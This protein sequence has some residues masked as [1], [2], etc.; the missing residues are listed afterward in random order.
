MQ[1]TKPPSTT[2]KTSWLMARS[3]RIHNIWLLKLI[4]RQI[5]G[6]IKLPA[7]Q[8]ISHRTPWLS[9]KYNPERSCSCPV[10]TSLPQSKEIILR[11]LFRDLQC[12][13]LR[14]C[15]MKGAIS[16]A[17][18]API[19]P[20]RD[21]RARAP[22]CRWV[23]A[24]I[25]LPELSPTIVSRF[26]LDCFHFNTKRLSSADREAHDC[27]LRLVLRRCNGRVCSTNLLLAKGPAS[28]AI[29]PVRLYT[30]K[31]AQAA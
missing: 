26:A 30:R 14:Y 18:K 9:I 11:N 6:Y 27:R 5:E 28:E 4:S 29:R 15:D 19:P 1:S 25:T 10:C 13:W 7:A 8:M 22:G 24:D 23:L 21:A 12:L 17:E 20:E 16:K 31:L 2:S 3:R